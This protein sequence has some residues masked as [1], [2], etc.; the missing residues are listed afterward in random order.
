MKCKMISL[1]GS[2][3]S[4]S[5]HVLLSEKYFKLSQFFFFLFIYFSCNESQCC[6]HTDLGMHTGLEQCKGE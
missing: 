2:Q 3:L 4:K 5:K 6:L 1:Y